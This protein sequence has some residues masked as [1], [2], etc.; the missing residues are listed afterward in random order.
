L[1]AVF[2]QRRHPS[3]PVRRGSTTRHTFSVFVSLSLHAI[4]AANN[5]MTM[6]VGFFKVATKITRFAE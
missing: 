3:T 1:N 4:A 2:Q 6:I 5:A